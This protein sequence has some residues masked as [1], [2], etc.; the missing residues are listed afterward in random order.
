MSMNLAKFRPMKSAAP[1]QDFDFR[2]IRYPVLASPKF[3]GIRCVVHPT[4]GVVSNTLKAIPNQ[5]IQEYLGNHCPRYLDGEL[6]VGPTN[7]PNVAQATQSGVM[8]RDGRPDFTYAVFDNFEAGDMCGFGIRIEDARRVITKARNEGFNNRIMFVEHVRLETYDD[9]VAYEAEQ[10]GL[11]YEGIMLRSLDGKYK[12]GRSTLKE[13]GLIKVKRYIDDEAIIEGWEPLLRNQNDPEI[14]A[15]G[16]QR[17]GYGKDGKVIDDT[18]VGNFLVRGVP[19]S[20]WAG[21]TFSVGSGLTDDERVK[22]RNEFRAADVL[23]DMR[24]PTEYFETHSS[25][26]PLG[27]QITYK[28]QAHGSKDAPRQPI[29]KGFRHIDT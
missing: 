1:E 15:L 21:V 10:V 28:Y 24:Y 11:G 22:F 12:F 27:K 2:S 20:R 4:L 23:R 14:D 19:S 13:G 8:S 16:L 18:R 29:W 6:L 5:F 9:F 17:R 26:S 3:D 7:H 25:G